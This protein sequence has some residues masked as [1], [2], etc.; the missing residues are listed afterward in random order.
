M[1]WGVTSPLMGGHGRHWLKDLLCKDF[2]K[3]SATARWCSG[4]CKFANG[5]A[6]RCAESAKSRSI[7]STRYPVDPQEVTVE[8]GLKENYQWPQDG[9]ATLFTRLPCVARISR[10][11]RIARLT[12]LALLTFVTFF[13]S[14]ARHMSLLP[15]QTIFDRERSSAT[16]SVD[17]RIYSKAAVLRACYWMNRDLHFRIEEQ[18]DCFRVTASRQST[19][20]TL[21]DP[22]PKTID[23]MLPEFFD[24]LQDSQLRVE[25]QAETAAVRELI[26]AK[27]FAESG[28]LEDPPPGTFVDPV[29]TKRRGAEK[30]ISITTN[31]SD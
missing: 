23:E 4:T 21:A 16:F 11:T 20:P 28:V 8:A 25:I 22:R 1:P 29:D 15:D 18:G 6:A 31:Q 2:I 17:K 5:D 9:C 7:G 19:K 27:A 10:F 26:I 24:A 13:P 30:L 3:V 14:F 12:C